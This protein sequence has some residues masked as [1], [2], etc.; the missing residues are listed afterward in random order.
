MLTV[1]F[2]I[3]QTVNYRD[4]YINQ[5]QEKGWNGKSLGRSI[6]TFIFLHTKKDKRSKIKITFTFRL[7]INI[8]SNWK[9]KIKSQDKGWNGKSVRRSIKG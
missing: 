2:K 6:T 7:L 3:V 8:D 9:F 1:K 4:D 5:S